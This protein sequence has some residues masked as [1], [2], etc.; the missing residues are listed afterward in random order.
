MSAFYEP[1]RLW[2][3]VIAAPP[4]GLRTKIAVN[5]DRDRVLGIQHFCLNRSRETW[6]EGGILGTGVSLSCRDKV[7][8]S[9][10]SNDRS[11]LSHN[12]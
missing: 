9:K 11:V 6:L 7:P 12:S 5:M 10:G 1:H 3:F 4:E 2:H 8:L